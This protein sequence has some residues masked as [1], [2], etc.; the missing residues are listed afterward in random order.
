MMRIDVLTI[1]PGM[2]KGPLQESIIKRAV[3]NGLV[4][5]N[6]VDIRD[7]STDKHRSVDAY[8]YG[9]GAGMVMRPEPIFAAYDALGTPANK[10]RTV[11]L[12]PR[13]SVFTQAKARELSA[14]EHLILVCGHY[15]GIDERVVLHLADEDL[16]IGDYVLS[17]GEL[18]A[19]VVIDAVVRLLPGALGAPES[20]EEES[21]SEGLLEYP[22]YTRPR[23]FR[24]HLVPEVLLSGHHEAIR[25][26][27][28]KESMRRTRLKRPDIFIRLC[29]NSED[30]EIL[31][32]IEEEEGRE[33]TWTC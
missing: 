17:G 24:G 11:L 13:G 19:L 18:A 5:I 31:R 26:W 8:P 23:D 22:Q 28:R 3:E 10:H 7:F 4:S 1:F 9:G 27:R 32:E 30:R 2:F 6:L 29:L 14:L 12:S 16:S 15:E 20:L 33:G 25:R 21:F